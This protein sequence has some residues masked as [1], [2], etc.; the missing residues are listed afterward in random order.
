MMD[1]YVSVAEMIAIEKAADATGLTYDQMMANAGYALAHAVIEKYSHQIDKTILG[2][3]GKGNNGGDTLVALAHLLEDGWRTNAYLIDSRP[4]DPLV[5]RYRELGG[6]IILLSEDKKLKNLTDLVKKNAILMDGL[7]GTGIH[8]PLRGPFPEILQAVHRAVD[9]M[10]HPPQIVAVD[11]PSGIDCESGESA[12]DVLPADITVCMAAVK[13]GLLTFP[14]YQYLGELK[15]VGIGLPEDL[16]PWKNIHRFVINKEFVI[17]HLPSRPLDAHKGTF[18]T[19][20]IVAG[21]LNFSGSALLA[22]QAAF[23]SGAGWVTLAVPSPLHNALAGSF[24]EA[25]WLHLPHEQGVISAESADL[26]LENLSRITT[27]LL[28]PGFGMEGTTATFMDRI[29]VREKSKLRSKVG[30]LQT[31][32]VE[33]GKQAPILPPLVI[34]ADGLKLLSQLDEW[35]SRLPQQTI[36]TPHPGEMSFLTGLDKD[37]IQAKRVEVAETYAKKWGHVVVLKGAFT[38][39]AEPGG[40]TGIIPIATPALARAGTGDVLAGL[41][42]GLRAQGMGAYPAAACGAWLHAQAG[43]EAANRLGSTAGVLAG[44]LIKEIPGL[45]PI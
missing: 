38:V 36:L 33:G 3:V 32:V 8:L 43:L 20:M 28:G 16:K 24:P 1:K 42:T 27:L 9:S 37:E 10:S 41:I 7:L 29:L 13:Q 19:V 23:R 30:L 34:D 5:I 12:P 6:D 31:E 11:C 21:S 2:L 45:M 15:V 22:G 25:T 40:Q 18:G 17:D 35:P 39:V 14:A 4:N 26:V 44:D